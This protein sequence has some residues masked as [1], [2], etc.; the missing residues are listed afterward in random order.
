MELDFPEELKEGSKR[1]DHSEFLQAD[2]NP[3]PSI[4]VI[5]CR[6]W[7]LMSG[8]LSACYKGCLSPLLM[9]L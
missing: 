8:I 1:L 2:R 6:V 5:T 3:T 9:S 7:Q 4:E